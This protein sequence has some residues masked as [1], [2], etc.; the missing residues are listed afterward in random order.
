MLS[1]RAADNHNTVASSSRQ[2]ASSSSSD[3]DDNDDDMNSSITELDSS[4]AEQPDSNDD[5][6]MDDCESVSSS[7]ITTEHEL[8]LRQQDVDEDIAVSVAG[9]QTTTETTHNG[10]TPWWLVPGFR[11]VPTD[12]EIVQHYLKL[13]V[14]NIALPRRHP[15]AE[16]HNVYALDAD[17]I[18]LDGRNGDKERLG[19]FFAREEDKGTYS[20][21]CYHATPEGYWRIRGRPARVRQCGRT[22]AFKTPMDFYRGRPPHG[23]RT[24]WSMFEYAL[25]AADWR[26]DGLRNTTQPWMNSY[27]VCKVRKRERQQ[28][29]DGRAER[30]CRSLLPRRSFFKIVSPRSFRLEKIVDGAPPPLKEEETAPERVGGEKGLRGNRMR[31]NMF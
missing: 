26:N 18:P 19:F 22:I 3:D 4:I 25:N 5:G 14:L 31:P 21:G 27:V 6:D 10:D 30:F 17:E 15:V 11:F 24:P 29:S 12:Q 16:G 1:P 13:K 8:L 23:Y 9:E 28:A 20:N 7:T 2:L